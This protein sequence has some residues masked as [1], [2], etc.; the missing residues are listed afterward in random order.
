MKK[1]LVVFDLDGTL[2]NTLSDIRR[3]INYVLSS[4]DIPQIS[5]EETREYVGHGLRS[6]L[7]KAVNKSGAMVED[8]DFSL[9]NELLVSSYMKHP[10]VY[11]KPYPGIE[12]LLAWLKENG[13]NVAIASNKKESVVKEIVSLSFPSVKFA[14]VLGENGRYPLKPD[15]E[16]ILSEINKLGLSESDIIYIGDSEVDAETAENLKC[17]SIIVSYGFRT[18]EELEKSGVKKSAGSPEEVMRIIKERYL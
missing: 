15:P 11:T 9:M 7:I 18:R 12:E 4:Y 10:C 8:N 6:A 16:G 1:K 5:E 14:F 3:A 17:D 13:L 2:L